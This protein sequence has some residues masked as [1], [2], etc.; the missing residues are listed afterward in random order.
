MTHTR[1]S[2]A[3][4]VE[5]L[6]ERL[7]CPTAV[8]RNHAILHQSRDMSSLLFFAAPYGRAK[9]SVSRTAMKRVVSGAMITKKKMSPVNGDP[10]WEENHFW[11]SR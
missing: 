7:P 10:S 8:A 4:D 1:F 9:R 2:Y 3:P 5:L 11:S 6:S